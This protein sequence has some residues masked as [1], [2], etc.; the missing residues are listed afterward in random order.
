MQEIQHTQRATTRT[1][2]NQDM[3]VNR[4]KIIH[5]TH[6][7]KKQTF[8]K[9][10]LGV[11]YWNGQRQVQTGITRAQHNPYPIDPLF[12]QDELLPVRSICNNTCLLLVNI[13]L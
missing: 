2:Q 12:V 6:R 5:K 3:D 9:G 11:P 10:K 7:I 13:D 4:D 1:A 8:I